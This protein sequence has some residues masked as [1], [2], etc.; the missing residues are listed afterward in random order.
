MMVLIAK[1]WGDRIESSMLVFEYKHLVYP[2]FLKSSLMKRQFK[3]ES[4]PGRHAP[5]CSPSGKPTL[6]LVHSKLKH[7]FFFVS[8]SL[9][10][11]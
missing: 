9:Y 11:F 1:F 3:K 2:E 4:F 8:A 6:V 7:I 10:F 5:L